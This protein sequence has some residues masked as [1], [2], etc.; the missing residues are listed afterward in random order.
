[1]NAQLKPDAHLSPERHGRITGSRV[2]AIL[3]LNPYQSR[4]DV[5]RSMVREHFD[6]APEFVGNDAT[7]YGQKMEPTAI[8]KYEAER[9]VMT[10]GGGELVKHPDHDFLCVTPDGC[11]GDDG[12][13]ECKAP[14]RGNYTHFDAAPYY[15]PQMHLQMHCTGRQWCDF[16]VLQR[17]GALHISRLNRDESWLAKHF[18]VLLGF[19]DDYALALLE[20]DAHLADKDRGDADWRAAA[21]VWR[22]AQ[23]RLAEAKRAADKARDALRALAGDASARGAGVQVIRMERAGSIAYARA[24]KAIAPDADLSEYTSEPTIVFSVKEAKQ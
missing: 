20:P 9:G 11:V 19:M 1:M 10:F 24:L 3:G 21:D 15:V 8:A 5:L 2:A 4:A 16:A 7:R 6:A 23:A 12:L 17:D 22:D 18:P 13:I 14:F